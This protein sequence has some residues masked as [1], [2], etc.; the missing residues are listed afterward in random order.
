M[1]FSE[2]LRQVSA[3]AHFGAGAQKFALSP[4][5]ELD[6]SCALCY[7]SC[8]V[9]KQTT[10]RMPVHITIVEDDED[11]AA[12]VAY[13]LE[14]QGW[15]CTLV[16]HGTEGWEHIRSHLP[17]CVILDLMLPGMDGM[18]IMREMKANP[19]TAA[20]P[21]LFLTARTELEER[22]EG[23]RLGADDYIGKPFSCKELVLRVQNILA[24]I[25]RGAS[26]AVIQQGLLCLDKALM[27]AT[28]DG[29]LLPLTTAE[30]KLLAFLMERPDK[31]QDR[32]ELQ[33]AVLGYSDTTPTRALDTHIKRLRQK[34]GSYAACV[35]TERG[36][37]YYFATDTLKR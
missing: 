35:A 25:N 13:N 31:V 28:L 36:V 7:F 33:R 37:G 2:R 32:Y 27:Q 24:R 20:I 19:Q 21:V 16:H 11:I 3:A 9:S 29:E 5:V 1:S 22:L 34:L 18:Q 10:Q 8:A 12:L 14:R 30:F 4:V 15:L 6:F 23:L 17:D 26:K